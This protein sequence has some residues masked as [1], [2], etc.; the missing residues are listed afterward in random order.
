MEAVASAQASSEAETRA[1]VDLLVATKNDGELL[2]HLGG[3]GKE[4]H[5]L[6]GELVQTYCQADALCRGLV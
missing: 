5:A 1:I 4:E 3:I 2:Q 6:M